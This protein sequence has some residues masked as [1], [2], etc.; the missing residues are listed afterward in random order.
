MTPALY[1]VALERAGDGD[2]FGAKLDVLMVA[3]GVGSMIVGVI[4]HVLL[5]RDLPAVEDPSDPAPSEGG[6]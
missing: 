4:D 2:V 3:I 6:A 5:R 1:D